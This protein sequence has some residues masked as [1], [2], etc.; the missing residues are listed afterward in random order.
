MFFGWQD[1]VAAAT[2]S[3]AGALPALP[4][5]NLQVNPVTRHTRVTGT[6]LTAD[7][8]AGATTAWRAFVLGFARQGFDPTAAATLRLML[9]DV[10]AGGTDVDDTGTIALN[11][12]AGYHQAVHVLSATRNARYVRMVLSD[13]TL[14]SIDLGRLAAYGGA[15]FWEPSRKHQI[16]RQWIVQDTTVRRRA[17]LSGALYRRVGT[18]FRALELGLV[19]VDRADMLAN[20]L[21]ADLAVGLVGDVLVMLDPTGEPTRESIWGPLTLLTPMIGMV[22]RRE[23]KRFLVEQEL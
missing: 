20:A 7:I 18:R 2:L 17:A 23:S 21:A 1:K 16:D 6:T 5:Q 19:H 22:G 9:S 10:A 13:A 3:V 14:S 12:A 8:D 11:F 15:G 4:G